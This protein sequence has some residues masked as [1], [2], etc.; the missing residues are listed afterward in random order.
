MKALTLN[1]D[2]DAA[3]RPRAGADASREARAPQQERGRRRVDAILDAASAILVEEGTA[4]LTVDAIARRSGTSKSSMYHFFPDCAHVVRALAERH[5][6]NILERDL[7]RL[8]EPVD[9]SRLTLEQTVDRYLDP[10]RT[11]L[12][13]HP[14]LLLI[15]AADS[16]WGHDAARCSG[17][18]ALHLQQAERIIAARLPGVRPAECRARALTLFAAVLGIMSVAGGMPA[19][20]RATLI[21]GLNDVVAGYLL[22]AEARC[23]RGR[24]AAAAS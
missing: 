19:A 21:R 1:Q 11:Y 2:A 3:T 16:T 14:D 4:G 13:E 24:G 7:L 17:L 22:R 9:W 15:L 10:F 6:S 20:Q 12:D 5:I 18:E 8:N 23:T